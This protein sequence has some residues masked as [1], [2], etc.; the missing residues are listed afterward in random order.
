[1]LFHLE[2]T[3]SWPW[4]QKGCMRKSKGTKDHLLVDKLVMFLTK[5]N[6]RNLR[7]I[8]IDYRKAYDSMP[9]TWILEVLKLYK[10]A[11]NVYNFLLNSMMLW[12]TV[13]TLNG[14]PL[15]SVKIQRGIF[16]G[17]SLSPLL[18]Y[19]LC[20]LCCVILTRVLKL[21]MW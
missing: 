10:I 11:D 21:T 14:Q 15:G 1:M 4:E 2:Q 16:Q 20:H 8:W 13:L 9:H 7:M 12:K 19:F 17:D 3:Q 6:R 18:F 5:R